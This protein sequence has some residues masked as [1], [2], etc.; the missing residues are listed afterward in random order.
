LNRGAFVKK[1]IGL[2]ELGTPQEQT[3]GK[4]KNVEVAPGPGQEESLQARVSP[5]CSL[6]RISGYAPVERDYY[7]PRFPAK[8][9]DP[10]LI[11][12][13]FGKFPTERLYLVPLR[14]HKHIDCLGDARRQVVV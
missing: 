3:G 6:S 10:F 1:P 11:L 12:R 13:V 14:F 5:H 9:W 2:Y 7:P 8:G 4:F